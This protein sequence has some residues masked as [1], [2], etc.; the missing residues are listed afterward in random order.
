[1]NKN[2]D[3]AIEEQPG[4][5]MADVARLAGVA[6]STVSRALANPGRVN[7]KTRAKINAAAKQLGYTPNAMA[8]GLRVGKSNIIMIILPGS[9]YYG[10]S[11]II[12]QVLQSINKSLIQGGYNLM[13]ANLDRDEISERHI[14]DLAFGGSV[15]GAIILSSKLP[16]V[17]GR[18]LASSGLPIVS[19]LLDMSDA[20]LQSVVTNDREAVRDVTAELIRL[21]HRRFFYLAGPEGNY[22]DVERYGGVLEALA[23]AGLSKEAVRRSGGRLDYQHGF[24]I[25]VQAADDF[26]GLDEKP[27]AV[28]AT[29]DDMAISFV[30]CVKRA[31][32]SIPDDL[33]VVSFDGSPVC[34]FSSPPL[35]TIEQPVEEMGRAAVDLLLDAL[36]QSQN[37]ASVPT[38]I[39]S[40]LILRES[41]APPKS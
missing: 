7:E 13:I 25:G 12:P 9:L 20:G 33:S 36:G 23:A 10:V 5:L 24:D 37:P 1:M 29:S 41:I 16:E 35:S 32:L 18:S 27:T 6:I 40:R 39:R 3:V 31:G 22:H 30:S 19:M 21:G 15:R 8:R 34:E 38:V 11:Q 17:D 2:K 4:A 26:A 14:L 28:I